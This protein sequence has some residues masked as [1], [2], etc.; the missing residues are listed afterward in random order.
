MSATKDWSYS[1]L[2]VT[3]LT[4]LRLSFSTGPRCAY[5]QWR[6]LRLLLGLD[7]RIPEFSHRPR[8]LHDHGLRL[9]DRPR[10]H[11]DRLLLIQVLQRD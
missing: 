2:E 4:R 11:R 10:Q 1:S 9:L 6:L 3:E 7:L 5:R 8:N